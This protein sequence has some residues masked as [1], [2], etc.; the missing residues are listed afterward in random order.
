[1]WF[2]HSIYLSVFC[3]IKQKP[4]YYVPQISYLRNENKKVQYYEN[5]ETAFTRAA[6]A[7]G[8]MR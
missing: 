2:C 4:L 6:F 1:M 7:Y 8:F 5:N 3:L